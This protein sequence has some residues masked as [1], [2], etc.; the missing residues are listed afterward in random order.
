MARQLLRDVLSVI[1]PG[2]KRMRE[3][4]D[5]AQALL[6]RISSKAPNGCDVVLTGSMAKRTFLRDRRDVD[7]FVLFDRSFPKEKL[8]P[9]IK[10]IVSKAFPKVGYQLSYAEHPYAR[11]HYDGR[12]IDLVP[13]YKI[14][15][16]SERLSA[17]D[18]SVLH[19]RFIR[20]NLKA[21]QRDDVLLL[22]QFL[23]A[24][25]LYGAEI[26]IEGYSGYLC[27]LLIVRYGSFMKLLRAAAKWKAPVFIDIAKHYTKKEVPGA[28]GRFG[29]LIVIDPTDKHR[30]VAAAVSEKN[31]KAFI[32]LCKAFLKKPSREH[33]LRRPQTFEQRISKVK[34]KA[35]FLLSMPRPNVVDD[36]LWGQLHRM[37]RQMEDALED[38]SP[39]RIL[40][41]DTQHLVR[42]AVFL[43]KCRLPSK[44]LVQG[45]PLEM[46][47]H[48][49]QFR[50]RHPRARFTKKKGKLY[51]EVK[52]PVTEARKAIKRFLVEFG[53]TKSHLGYAEELYILEE[54]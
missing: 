43:D 27:E 22:K 53:E 7:I 19:T 35:G 6:K 8:E 5:F 23:A 18:R 9:A 13:A 45:P 21:A 29:H 33:F 25:G 52:R 10:R 38:F 49:K 36:V 54:L 50:K 40:A 30:N 14:T 1:R 2:P 31:L 4:M 16:A 46:K 15:D 37:M 12:R 32:R 44:M 28:I 41:E 34:A 11:F 48:V 3:E 24:N 20:K 51:A 17:V 42:I 26:R 47:E 39:K